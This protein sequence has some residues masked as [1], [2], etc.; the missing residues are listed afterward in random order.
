[1]TFT[2]LTTIITIITIITITITIIP[3]TVTTVPFCLIVVRNAS[4]HFFPKIG[5]GV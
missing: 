1:M 4:N 2:I 3:T 5:E